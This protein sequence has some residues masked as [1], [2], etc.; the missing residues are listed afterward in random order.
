MRTQIGTSFFKK[1]LL[2]YLQRSHQQQFTKPIL[3]K[4]GR[5]KCHQWL[6]KVRT[7]LSGRVDFDLDQMSD[8]TDPICCSWQWPA[9]ENATSPALAPLPSPIAQGGPA[10][11]LGCQGVAGWLPWAWDFVLRW[12]DLLCICTTEIEPKITPPEAHPA[13]RPTQ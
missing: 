8:Q 3:S 11:P 1:Y 5:G 12:P 9:F 10:P 6:V 13:L 2:G 7:F 4:I